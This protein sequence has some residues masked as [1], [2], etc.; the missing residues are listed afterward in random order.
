MKQ[1]TRV[2]LVDD[3]EVVRETLRNVLIGFDCV[4]SDAADG[5]TAIE[6]L[7]TS[8]FD[9]VFLDVRLPDVSGIDVLRQARKES[10]VTGKVVVMTALPDANTKAEAAELGAFIYLNKLNWDELRAVFAEATLELLPPPPAPQPSPERRGRKRTPVA[11]AARRSSRDIESQSSLQKLL[12]LDD[13]ETWLGIVDQ[14]L[15]KEFELT[16]TIDADEA[17]K[18]AANEH[19]DL[20]ILDMKLVGGVSGLDILTRMRKTWPYLRGIIFTGDPSYRSAVES[21]RRGAL[22]YVSK[23]EPMTLADSVRKILADPAKPIRIFLSYAKPD[24]PQVFR[25]HEKLTS[26]GFLPWMD[27]KNIIG[28]TPW[29]PAIEKAIEEADYFVSCLSNYSVKATGVIQRE[30]KQAMFR[31]EGLLPGSI[32]IIPARLEEL[33]VPQPFNQ[34][35]YIDLFKRD[36]F[37]ELLRAFSS[38]GGGGR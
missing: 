10:L 1:P 37:Q 25:L 23:G 27:K 14:M 13:N 29:Q 38:N 30:L 12:V 21:G 3:K 28:G 8:E 5:T 22:D 35:Q 36:G 2:L 20:V 7:R 4:F 32:F 17:C 18:L 6:C 24:R 11:Q 26:R 19:F 31:Q 34:W 16:P 33:P 9:V 15:G